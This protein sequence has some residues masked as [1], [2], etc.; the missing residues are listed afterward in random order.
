[1][2]HLMAT[3]HAPKHI[4]Q[5]I[6]APIKAVLNSTQGLRK[7]SKIGIPKPALAK[8]ATIVE[9]AAAAHKAILRV[10]CRASLEEKRYANIA[11]ET[12][13]NTIVIKIRSGA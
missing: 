5:T 1:M 8:N 2:K 12:R 6:A 7:S 13:A 4:A 9:T 3:N 11:V 10:G